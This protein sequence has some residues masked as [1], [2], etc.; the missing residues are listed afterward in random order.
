MKIKPSLYFGLV[1]CASVVMLSACGNNDNNPS[2]VAS[3]PAASGAAGG[4]ATKDVTI[5]AANWKF[6]QPEIKVKQGDTINLTLTNDQG[7]H[8]IEIADLGVKVKN[9]E[10]K[11]FTVNKAGTYEYHC[12]I[13]CGQGHA[14]MIG[15]LVVE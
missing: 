11:S 5:H 14:D 12:N 1:A 3:T 6:D 15:N 8:G 9:G 2:P 13:Q 10:T 7:V 4:G